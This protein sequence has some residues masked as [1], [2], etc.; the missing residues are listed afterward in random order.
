MTHITKAD[1][2]INL[3]GLARHTNFMPASHFTKNQEKRAEREIW[4]TVSYLVIK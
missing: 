3:M 2:V 4:P 1:P